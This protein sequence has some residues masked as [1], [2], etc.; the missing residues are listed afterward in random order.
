MKLGPPFGRTPWNKGL[1]IGDK[2]RK[3]KL[4]IAKEC[5]NCKNV[6]YS[7]PSSNRKYCNLSCRSKYTAIKHWYGTKKKYKKL[8]ETIGRKFGKPNTC[9][10]CKKNNLKKHKIHWANKT[11]KYLQKRQDWLRLCALCHKQY[12]K[13]IAYVH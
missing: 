11:G 2:I 7:Y 10:F 1:K 12:D 4:W 6:F 5:F 3:K 13:N 9:E 8:H